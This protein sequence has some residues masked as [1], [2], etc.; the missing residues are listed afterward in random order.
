MQNE[1]FVGKL[2]MFGRFPKSDFSFDSEEFVGEY[3]KIISSE[4]L[5]DELLTRMYIRYGKNEIEKAQVIGFVKELNLFNLNEEKLRELLTCDK[6][7]IFS[8]GQEM[9]TS[10]RLFAQKSLYKKKGKMEFM[11]D[12][13]GFSP[14]TFN[15]LLKRGYNT[16]SAVLQAYR[17]GYITSEKVKNEIKESLLIGNVLDI[18]QPEI[19]MFY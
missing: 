16:K 13:F 1:N 18:S 10:I 8:I 19:G 4:E 17:N 6:N 3:L 14:K 15:Y 7:L 5:F 9:E 12:E 2:K 11:I